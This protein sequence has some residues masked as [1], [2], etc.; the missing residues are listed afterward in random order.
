M[1]PRKIML[2]ATMFVASCPIASAIEIT[3]IGV[4][5]TENFD[6]LASVG[7]SSVLPAGWSLSES[8]TTADTTYGVGTGSSTTGNT[9]SFG[10][11]GSPER[12]LGGLLSG[13]L[14]PVFGVEIHNLTGGLINA[15]DIG[16]VGE[17]WRLGALDREDR[18][19]FQYSLVAGSLTDVAGSWT[20]VDAL[21]FVAPAT[22][23]S[24][25]LRDGNLAANRVALAMS[26]VGLSI[27]DGA[28]VWLRWVDFN[29]S[30][31]DDALAI[32][33]FT[34]VA[35]RA[36]GAPGQAVPDAFPMATGLG[37]VL[38]GLAVVRRCQPG[39]G[40]AG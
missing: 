7:T 30:G 1:P 34:L 27:A 6:T 35:G 37:L 16:Y 32:D 38:L 31:F 8:G 17:Q 36:G 24:I 12:A 28:S 2:V 20:D 26:I 21:D 19:D 4:I 11:A 33:D 18:L 23:P 40:G 39:L 25:G 3:D 15:L 5:H 9:Y 22:G 29:A 13:T 14:A 10:A